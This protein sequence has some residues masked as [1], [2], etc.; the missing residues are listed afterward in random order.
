MREANGSKSDE[1][2]NDFYTCLTARLAC[3]CRTIT[4]FD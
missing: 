1:L 3:R 2:N 4:M